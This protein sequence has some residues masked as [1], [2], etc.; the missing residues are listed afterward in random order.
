VV[1]KMLMPVRPSYKTV[2]K[3]STQTINERVNLPLPS[4]EGLTIQS[5]ISI[6]YR[7]VPAKAS[8]LFREVGR[9]YEREL[10]D[11]V[12]RSA[13]AD[14]SARFFAKDLHSGQ[15]S[16]IERE[17]EERMNSILEPRGIIIENVLM[18]S[19]QLPEGLT[20]AIE[21][22]L[23]AEQEAQRRIFIT[24]QEK[25]D[26]ERRVIQAEGE[27]DASILAAEAEKRTLELRAEAKANA[28]KIQADA[29]AHAIEVKASAEAKSNELLS[30]YVSESVLKYRGIEAMLELAG[31]PSSKLLI[32]PGGMSLL[33][34]P[35][36]FWKELE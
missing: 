8:D 23:K 17:I 25:A 7:V 13:A 15:R 27:R 30:K 19:I 21:E 33:G 34:L 12:F 22:K 1:L 18:K 3:I 16:E 5:E 24:Q 11:P 6:L 36:E 2:F 14:V 20:L 29:E 26:A 32:N 31:S 4:K 35:P 9:N 10:I 28:T